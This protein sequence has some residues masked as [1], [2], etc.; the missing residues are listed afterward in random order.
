MSLSSPEAEFSRAGTAIYWVTAGAWH[1]IG[2][3]RAVIRQ[4]L[5]ILMKKH[6]EAA[7]VR[8]CETGRRAGAER[9]RIWKVEEDGG[10]G[11]DRRTALQTLP[12]RPGSV[13]GR[14]VEPAMA[15]L[16]WGHTKGS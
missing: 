4:L 6:N 13:Q 8:G 5:V 12:W 16:V 9:G 14:S 1:A 10:G 2:A 11:D 15:I 3:H 7:G